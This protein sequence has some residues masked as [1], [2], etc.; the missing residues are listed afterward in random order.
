MPKGCRKIQKQVVYYSMKH[1]QRKCNKCSCDLI[2]GDNWLLSSK[3]N[4]IYWCKPC[5]VVKAK[6]Y[7]YNNKE[8]LKEYDKLNYINKHKYNLDSK[9]KYRVSAKKRDDRIKYEI[10]LDKIS[11][12]NQG[13]DWV[14]YELEFT[15][16][17]QGFSF[18]KFGITQHSIEY[19]YNQ[20]AAY[21][22]EVLKEITGD[23]DYIKSLERKIK[24]D[25]KE[26]QFNFP[27]GIKFVGL[28]ECRVYL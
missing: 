9:I 21:T 13:G 26:N 10:A 28:S 5:W 25:T 1:T 15:H 12:G 8:K 23:K 2:V 27:E 18:Y 19:R 22:Y 20:Y 14:Y 4:Q 7:N 6:K 16:K 17:E 3:N 24:M 11:K